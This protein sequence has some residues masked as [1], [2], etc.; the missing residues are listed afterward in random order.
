MDKS[1]F[2]TSKVECFSHYPENWK[3]AP[4]KYYFDYAKGSNAALYTKEFLGENE[5]VVPVYSGQTGNSGILGY[6]NRIDFYNTKGIIVSTVGA[7]AM[8]TKLVEGDFCLSQNCALLTNKNNYDVNY[9]YYLL[10]VL[11]DFEKNKLANVMIPSLRF[12]DLD[13]YSILIPPQETQIKIATFLDH[14]T[15]EIDTIIAKKENLLLLLEEKKKAVIN[16]A[17]TKGLNPNANMKESGIEWIGEIP[18]NWAMKSLGYVGTCQNGV[19]KGGEYFGTG[20]PFV[21]Y[22]DI[23]KNYSLPETVEG[24]ANSTSEDKEN[25][26]VQEGDVFF[27]RTSETIEEIGMAS[28]CLKT[29]ENAVF[30]GF[31]IRFRPEN[32]R[33]LLTNFS[34]YLFRSYY[35]RTSLVKEMNLVTRASLSQSVLKSLNIVIPPVQEQQLISDYLD[36]QFETT[37]LLKSKLNIQVEKLKEYRQSL[38][39]EAVTGKF[40]I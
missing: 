14:K 21:N 18:E 27:T 30:S 39:S 34:K 37:D 32:N 40:S 13:N 3:E 15:G 11:F 38:I 6:T 4:L 26:S 19:S 33:T 31:T 9:G 29:I 5:G 1:L 10:S 7:K 22:G 8:S 24:L 17:V 16:E 12:E 35:V 23:Y 25:Y 2:I 28:T 20:S 36:N